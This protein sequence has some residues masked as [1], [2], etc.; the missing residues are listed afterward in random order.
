MGEFTNFV[1]C[2]NP[3]RFTYRVIVSQAFAISVVVV[4]Q[5]KPLDKL[6]SKQQNVQIYFYKD[7]YQVFLSKSEL[8][9]FKFSV[10]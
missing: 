10:L 5:I 1:H 7:I 2:T 4:F 6:T 8:K 9:F 3:C